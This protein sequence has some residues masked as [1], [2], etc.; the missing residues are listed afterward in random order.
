MSGVLTQV[1]GIEGTF[2]GDEVWFHVKDN[3]EGGGDPD[4]ISLVLVELVPIPEAF[5]CEGPIEELPPELQEDL[6]LQDVVSG[7]I[8]VSDNGGGNK[9]IK[10]VKPIVG[11]Q[12]NGFRNV[13]IRLSRGEEVTIVR[14]G[15]LELIARCSVGSSPV[16]ILF[17]SSEDDW[18]SNSGPL[19]AGDEVFVCVEAGGSGH[20]S[21]CGDGSA[22]SSSGHYL[23]VSGALSVGEDILGSD[24]IIVGPVIT[25]FE[26]GKN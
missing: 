11:T 5:T 25:T 2:I 24:C 4:Q 9:G 16:T 3:G 10:A 17:T 18:F 20:F 22:L 19:A 1:D 23:G 15:P 12:K 6:Q 8:Q 7:N 14:N 26:P 13:F 21:Q